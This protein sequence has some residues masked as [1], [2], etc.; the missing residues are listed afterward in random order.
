MRIS[1]DRY[2]RDRRKYH[3]AMWMVHHGARTRT[4]TQ[5][6]GLTKY[7]V[8]TL[9]RAYERPRHT[10]RHRGASPFQ[11]AYFFRSLAL[12]CETAVFGY[13]AVQT[14]TIADEVPSEAMRLL[15]GLERGERLMSAFEVYLA[16]VPDARIS[17]E[18]AILLVRE[19][20]ER[21]VLSLRHC[22]SCDGL[23]VFDRLGSQEERC[24][25]CRLAKSHAESSPGSGG[26]GTSE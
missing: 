16:L 19:L 25:F 11:P 12:E 3:L 4:I 17:L 5:W 14:K 7:R 13:I 26:A 21:N 1:D 24:P 22:D 20:S 18:H 6:T 2:E 15:P 8:R 10:K 23:I 9:V